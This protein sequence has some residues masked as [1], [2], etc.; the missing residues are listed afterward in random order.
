[1]SSHLAYSKMRVI[2]GFFNFVVT[3]QDAVHVLF[4]QVIVPYKVGT[5]VFG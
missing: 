3:L 4:G 5:L 2:P 1:M